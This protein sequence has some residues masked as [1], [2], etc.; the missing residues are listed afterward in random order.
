MSDTSAR[1]AA[2]SRFVVGIDLGTTN[3]AVAYVDT[4]GG[5]RQV[6]V[7]PIGQ[8]TAAGEVEARE[9]LPSFHY[10][11]AA[12]EFAE[13]ALRLPWEKEAADYCVG[14][15]ARDH[16]MRVPSRLI[17]SAKS[18]LSHNGV[19]RTAELLPWHGAED[20][21]RHS[22]VE[23]SARYLAHIRAAW[24]FR[25]PQDPLAEQDVALT[26][27]A[28]FDE[29]AR[30]L[31]VEASKRAG[32]PRVVLIEEPQAA[33]Y[34]WLNRNA[35]DWEQI[36]QPGHKILVCDIG[37]GTS[38]FT[39]IRARS[40]EDG[41]V[42]FHRVAVG[43]HLILGGDNLDL[44]LAHHCEQRLTG[45]EKLPPRQ[46]DVLVASCRRVKET[47]LGPDA[48]ERYTVNLPGSGARLLG[49]GQQIELTRDEVQQVLVDGFLPLVDLAEK[50]S[51]R[52]SGFQEFGLPYA[53]DAAITRYLAAFLT[54]HRHAG[55]D[56]Q[57]EAAAGEQDPARPDIVLFNGGLFA[58]TVLRRRMLEGLC[59][60]FDA[61]A[62]WQPRVLEAAR[63]DLAVACGAAYYG[64][65]RR[66]EGVRIAAELARTYYIGIEGDP[67]RAV[68]LMPADVQSGSEVELADR[69]FHLLVAEPAEFPLFVSSTRLTD[70]PGEVLPIDPEQMR[71]LPPIRTVIRGR[72]REA[73]QRVT[74]K[75]HARLT[76]IGTIELW[77]SE[78]DG[79]R[80]WRM[81]FDVRAATQT[82]IAAHQ[83]SG[84]QQGFVDEQTWQAVGD[85][86]VA[87]FGHEGKAKPADLMKRLSE[88]LEAPRDE[89]PMPLLR[90]IWETLIE[91]ADGRRRS[92]GHETRWLNLLGFALRPGYGVAMDD[93]R[94]SESWRL[95]QGQIVHPGPASKAQQAILWRRVAGGLSAGQ[96]QS[97]ADSIGAP[98]RAIHRR[99]QTGRGGGSEASLAPQETVEPIRLLGALELLPAAT[100][101]GLG[102]VL[103][104]LLPKRKMQPARSAIVWA[105]GRLGA[106]VPLYGPLNAV[107]AADVAGAW[108]RGV[109]EHHRDDPTDFLAAM[110]LA[111]KTDDRYRDL[112]S[113]IRRDVITW[114]QDSEAP[115]HFIELVR[116]G[117]RL[118][119]EEQSRIFGDSLPVGL[120][121]EA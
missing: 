18:W 82:D 113:D 59:R 66:G 19:D 11:P 88:A 43:E 74:V 33:F 52:K 15:L 53:A 48:P 14:V 20:V 35:D 96:Q 22:P 26:L 57:N 13:G 90:R 34:A 120:R 114:L 4:L 25:F 76:E 6:E 21:D 49:G 41:Q 55:E 104:D 98:I 91:L 72:R 2:P 108:V 107:V 121:L 62:G 79:S 103:L 45:G 23:V 40:G 105:L 37:G 110:Q 92:P 118:D 47:L 94:V 50:P 60:W 36:V 83:G 97:L 7:L 51:R 42:M 73:G 117:G 3:S 70:R 46:W 93:W 64:L 10:Q 99:M 32:L 71:S 12:G 84:E 63:L 56:S 44:A 78:R 30:E 31:T 119:S 116:K 77:C 29:V 16:G 111:R 87:T 17:N 81:Q 1:D 85:Q 61:G 75:L 95:V 100:K 109:I 80:S 102:E 115:A 89:W 9:T 68:C 86:L 8:L 101:R 28:S 54:A 65:V 69:T 39:L 5:G 67:P 112:E 106:R 27:P 58:S 24:D 38:D